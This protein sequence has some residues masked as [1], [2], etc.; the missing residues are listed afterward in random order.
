MVRRML[1]GLMVVG[2]VV[3]SAAIALGQTRADGTQFESTLGLSLPSF[4]R[5]HYSDEGVI[6][7]LTGFNLG[8]GYSMR[9]YNRGFEVEEFNLY[10]GWGTLLLIIPYVEFGL[11][12][13]LVVGEKGHLLVLDLGVIYIAP[14]LGISILY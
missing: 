14:R 4:G 2:V 3:A 5:V 10:W 6:N 12:Y 9:Y 8:L 7:K 11:S 1:C 13:P